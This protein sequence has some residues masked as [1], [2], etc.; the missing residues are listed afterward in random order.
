MKTKHNILFN[1]SKRM[2][3]IPSSSVHLVVTSPPYPMIEMWDDMFKRQN[4]EIAKALKHEKGLQAFE[5]M[6]RELDPVWKEI[7]RILINGGIACINIGDAVRTIDGDFRLY[8]NHSRILTAMLK[9]GFSAL[10]LILWRKPTNAPNKFMGSGMLPAGAYV[11]LEHEYILI[12][13]KGP[14]REFISRMKKQTRREGAFFWEERNRWFSDVWFG[15]IGTT[16]KMKNSAARLRSGAFPFELAYRLVNMYS[17][18][19]DT[20]VDPFL[21]TGTTMA[22]AMASARNSIGFEIE[23]GFRDQI[24]SIKDTVIDTSND[25]IRQRIQNHLEFVG[26]RSKEKGNPKYLNRHYKFPVITR[27]EIELFFNPL[28]NIEQI[29]EN[30]MAVTYSDVPQENFEGDWQE[31]TPPRARKTNANQLQLF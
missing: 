3:A 10:P 18:K 21:G 8:P 12:L 29:D 9:T 28:D 16:Q 19:G 7:R 14:K 31:L 24:F 15:L 25:R 13:R 20:V 23:P 6:H 26:E 1:N 17:T 27:Q 30:S 11:T 5:L 2:D 22:A 4:N